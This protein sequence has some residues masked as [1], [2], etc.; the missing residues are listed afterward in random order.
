MVPVKNFGPPVKL[1]IIYQL[2]SPNNV[3][4][5]WK[6][7]TSSDLLV[8]IS[9]IS[10]LEISATMICLNNMLAW[11]TGSDTELA[12][13]LGMKCASFLGQ[14]GDY[15]NYFKYR[16][17]PLVDSRENLK[18]C[19]VHQWV[20][21]TGGHNGRLCFWGAYLKNDSLYT[22]LVVHLASLR[23]VGSMSV[24]RAAKPLKHSVMTSSR[25]RLSRGKAELLLRAALNL[26]FLDMMED[27]D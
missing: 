23:S 7:P 24:E 27:T 25:N 22:N 13:E 9:E 21:N 2:V 8:E 15:V 18:L 11:A 4:R 19:H 5:V 6:F 16:P 20:K 1:V 12:A 3:T 10:N 17:P 26:K 14:S